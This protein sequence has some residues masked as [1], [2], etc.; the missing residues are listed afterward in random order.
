MTNDS[1]HSRRSHNW[2]FGI[3][4]AGRLVLAAKILV[5]YYR[6]A[7]PMPAPAMLSGTTHRTAW[8]PPAPFHSEGIEW[9]ERINEQ[10]MRRHWDESKKVSNSLPSEK[11]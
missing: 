6:S 10:I 8:H 7:P 11:P 1:S 3:V 5:I 9:G 4:V 2:C